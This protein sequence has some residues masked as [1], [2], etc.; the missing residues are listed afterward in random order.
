MPKNISD[1]QQIP[2]I[3]PNMELH[4]KKLGYQCVT[5][6]RGQN[7]EEMYERDIKVHGNKSDRCVLYVYRLAVYFAETEE[8]ER[9]AAKLQWW[10]WK[11]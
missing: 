10:N 7:P 9:E 6:L 5:D 3:G 8:S 2:S 11:D 4:L 1:L